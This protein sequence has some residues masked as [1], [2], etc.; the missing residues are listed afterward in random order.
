VTVPQMRKLEALR[1]SGLTSGQRK[2]V[3]NSDAS[4]GV[5]LNLQFV[6]A[7]VK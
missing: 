1:L 7:E 4:V 3:T 2:I 6:L 5:I